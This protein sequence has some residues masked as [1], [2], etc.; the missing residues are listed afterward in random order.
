MVLADRSGQL[1]VVNGERMIAY[2]K[3]SDFQVYQT[4]KGDDRNLKAPIFYYVNDKYKTGEMNI[5]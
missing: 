3:Y 2:S 5:M 4:I 1:L